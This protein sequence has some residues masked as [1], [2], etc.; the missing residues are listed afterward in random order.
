MKRFVNYGRNQTKDGGCFGPPD[1]GDWCPPAPNATGTINCAG[2]DTR[3]SCWGY[4]Q[5][6]AVMRDWANLLNKTADATDY[7][8]LVSSVQKA[9]Q[10]SKASSMSGLDGMAEAPGSGRNWIQTLNSLEIDIMGPDENGT[11]VDAIVA[12]V[13]GHGGHLQTGIIGTKYLF[14][15]LSRAGR[16]DV[17][18]TAAATP[19]FPGY[20]WMIGQGA[21]TLWE[22]WQGTRYQPGG[23]EGQSGSSWNHIMYGSQGSFYY[24]HVAGIRMVAPGWSRVALD[25]SVL[26]TP[27]GVPTVCERP[28]LPLTAAS[29]RTHTPQ[30][31]VA[32]AWECDPDGG[33]VGR[34]GIG[35]GIA[36]SGPTLTLRATV[37]IGVMADLYVGARFASA[38]IKEGGAPIWAGGHFVSGVAGITAGQLLGSGDVRFELAAGSYEITTGTQ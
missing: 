14:R 1:W 29:A 6:V 35:E 27:K 24:E 18:W 37:P 28:S 5:G 4:Y 16:A 20:G 26:R 38:S 25:P 17:A 22:N 11:L 8:A 2:G 3:V 33:V 7:T 15:S 9:W 10:H 13:I 30:G 32:L 21:T 12:D 34:A 31:V 23:S 36:S 19:D